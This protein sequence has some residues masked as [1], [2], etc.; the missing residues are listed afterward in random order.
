MLIE[1]LVKPSVEERVKNLNGFHHDT[2]LCMEKVLGRKIE[3]CSG[4]SSSGTSSNNRGICEECYNEA[5]AHKTVRKLSKASMKCTTCAKC[6]KRS[7]KVVVC[8][9][10]EKESQCDSDMET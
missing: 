6:S 5:S 3:N 7:Q 1:E 10:C 2:I 8:V 4:K 9:K